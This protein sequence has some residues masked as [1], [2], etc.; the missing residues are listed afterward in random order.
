MYSFKWSWIIRHYIFCFLKYRLTL[1]ICYQIY[2]HILAYVHSYIC[3][4]RYEM[5]LFI[6]DLL[7]YKI[8]LFF[9]IIL[10]F[11]FSVRIKVCCC[12]FMWLFYLVVQRK[13]IFWQPGPKTKY[14]K[15]QNILVLI[16]L[17]ISMQNEW[18]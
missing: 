8:R 15:K 7:F 1:S 17:W 3:T 18:I 6:D 4:V 9:V 12:D 11:L 14:V 2:T 16:H 5:Y 10:S 13:T